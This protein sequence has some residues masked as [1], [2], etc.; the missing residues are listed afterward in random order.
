MIDTAAWKKGTIL[1]VFQ[2]P[3]AS[4]RVRDLGDFRGRRNLVLFFAHAAGCVPCERKL[5][6]LESALA[7][8][9]EE[10]AEVLAIMPGPPEEA[11]AP[12]LSLPILIDS[13]ALFSPDAALLVCDRF[14][15]I[16]AIYRAG[17]DH[18]L[19]SAEEIAE[20]LAFIG[21]QCPE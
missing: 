16:F 18:H 4:G 21:V 11:R 8:L 3:E 13:A 10:E 12:A 2:L 14:G 20:D 19:P 9:R 6:E 15:E 7:G 1:P 17:E 5:R